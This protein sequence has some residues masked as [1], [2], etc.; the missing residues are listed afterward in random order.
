MKEKQSKTEDYEIYVNQIIKS[1][2]KDINNEFGL[3]CI[4]SGGKMPYDVEE[5]G[6]DFMSYH[7]ATIDEARKLEITV[8]EKFL[9]AI[10][11][12]EK[13]RPFLREYPFTVSRA[14]VS[15]SFHQPDKRRYSDG[16]VAFVFQVKDTIFYRS[17]DEH[18]SQ[19]IPLHKEPY[20]E[21]LKIV[22]NSSN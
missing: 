1:F 13:I 12:N 19:L 17:F 10:N 8:T 18:S 7:R 3:V 11:S 2:A 14:Q 15:I 20:D 22:S 16:S 5:I 4:G 9:N 6:I 21:A